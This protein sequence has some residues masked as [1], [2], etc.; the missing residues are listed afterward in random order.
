[1]TSPIKAAIEALRKK[2]KRLV[3]SQQKDGLITTNWP[4]VKKTK[5]IENEDYRNCRLNNS[6]LQ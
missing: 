5:F 2:L 3:R 6:Q 4:I 1:M